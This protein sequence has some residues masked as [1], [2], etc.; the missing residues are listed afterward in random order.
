M[1]RFS[2]L[3]GSRPYRSSRPFD[4]ESYDDLTS[5]DARM[6]SLDRNH[7][8]S[9]RPRQPSSSFD[10]D[11]NK[12]LAEIRATNPSDHFDRDPW[13]SMDETSSLDARA[14]ALDHPYRSSSFCPYRPL[15]TFD[16]DLAAFDADMAS[17]SREHGSSARHRPRPGPLLSREDVHLYRH[18][19]LGFEQAVQAIEVRQMNRKLK[20]MQKDCHG[21]ASPETPLSL[22]RGRLSSPALS[23]LR[24]GPPRESHA[25]P[26]MGPSPYTQGARLQSK[27]ARSRSPSPSRSCRDHCEC[28]GYCCFNHKLSKSYASNKREDR[29]GERARDAAS[30]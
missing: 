6:T 17:L 19:R 8:S 22:R 15:S 11:L 16:T 3:Q 9:S 24:C 23:T 1:S 18:D 7:G 28:E 26:L 21:K 2:S 13:D 25:R 12:T 5:L 30:D 10:Y 14:A 27:A 29:R 20:E 4:Y